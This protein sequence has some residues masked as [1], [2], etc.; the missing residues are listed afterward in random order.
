MRV[1]M[2]G[3]EFPPFISGGLGTA[4]YGLACAMEHLDLDIVMLLPTNTE[5]LDATAA[6]FCGTGLPLDNLRHVVF[7]VVPYKLPNPY[8]RSRPVRVMGTG[9]AGGYDGNLIDRVYEYANRC[10]DLVKDKTFDVIHAHDWV[11]FPAAVALSDALQKPL[12][13]HVH[14][15]EFDRSGE[16]INRAVYEIERQGMERACAVIAVSR[17]TA[18]ILVNHYAVP[19]NK[20]HVVHNG[21]N[22]KPADTRV[23]DKRRGARVLFLGRITSQKGPEYFVKAAEQVLRKCEN[24]KFVMAGWG[25]LAP[26]IVE[27]VASRRLGSRIL[28]TGFLRGGQVDLAYRMSDIYVMPSVSEPFGLTALEAVRQGLPVILSKTTGVGEILRNGALK[29]DFWDANKMADQIVDVLNNPF[30]AEQLRT[31]ASDEIR[32]LTWD[33]AAK[34]CLSVY[35]SVSN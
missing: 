19:A 7:R 12:V 20:I 17:Y 5:D 18:N 1:L 33:A 23:F 9:Q 35:N 27:M 32:N 14:A 25:D 16:H 2:L 11:T 8:H 13:V 15:T 21:I 6:G 3:W 4:C 28:F 29:V 10:T 24:V 26:D 31:T 30:L 22:P 34:K